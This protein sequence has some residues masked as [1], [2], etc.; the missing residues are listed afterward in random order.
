MSEKEAEQK[1]L[2]FLPAVLDF[3]LKYL[4]KEPQGKKGFVELR[5]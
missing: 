4:H 3:C 2:D 5:R 1:L